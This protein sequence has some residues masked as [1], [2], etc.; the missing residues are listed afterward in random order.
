[1]ILSILI[2]TLVDRARIRAPLLSELR[3]QIGSQ[4]VEVLLDEDNRQHT[5]GFK[6]NALLMRATGTYSVFVDDDDW[7]SYTYVRDILRVLQTQYVDCIGFWGQA[8]WEEGTTRRFVHSLMCP[9]WTEWMNKDGTPT[10][11]RH[12]NH[13]NPIRTD[14]ARRVKYRDITISEDHHWTWDL[15]NA[16]LLRREVFLGEKCL[17]HYRP[18]ASPVG[19]C[20][21]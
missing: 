6:R 11:Y 17:Y 7:I 8:K 1:M 4:P 9:V 14:L 3:K 15:A 19:I 10:Y 13:L 5:T 12:P 16:D 2:P 18:H 20:L 21:P